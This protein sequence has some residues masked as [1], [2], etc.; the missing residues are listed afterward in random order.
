MCLHTIEK[1]YE[2]DNDE[3]G[4]GYK[5]L[6]RKDDGSLGGAF[7]INVK[8]PQNVVI[9]DPKDIQ[10]YRRHYEFTGYRTGFHI[11][12]DDRILNL[13]SN[14]ENSQCGLYKCKYRNVTAMGMALPCRQHPGHEP[15][16]S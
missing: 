2:P 3:W 10:I 14:D 6:R 9:K 16:A 15:H 5:I 7:F 8:F 13:I 12:R 1:V 4:Y 11:I